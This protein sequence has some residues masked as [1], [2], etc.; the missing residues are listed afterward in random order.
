[1]NAAPNRMSAPLG[2]LGMPL[3]AAALL[4]VLVAGPAA[5]ADDEFGTLACQAGKV[6]WVQERTSAGTTTISWSSGR[7]TLRK[8]AWSVSQTR[9]GLRS[10]WWRV[11]TTGSMD[12]QVT[13]A[14]CGN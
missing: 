2:R 1:M 14:Y 6:V 9:T 8:T 3:V 13:G 12:H 10:T 4:V 7:R 11:S 5:A